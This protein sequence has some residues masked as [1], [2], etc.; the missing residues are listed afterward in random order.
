MGRFV[1]SHPCNCGTYAGENC[2]CETVG[3]MQVNTR[4][5][6]KQHVVPPEFKHGKPAV[7]GKDIPA[8]MFDL[9][10]IGTPHGREIRIEKLVSNYAKKCGYEANTDAKG[11]VWVYVKCDEKS[12]TTMFSCHMDT[13]HHTEQKIQL[14]LSTGVGKEASEMLY[15][16]DPDDTNAGAV[17]G[18][19]DKVGVFILL[20]LMQAGT[21]GLYMFHVGEEDGCVGSKWIRDTPLMAAKI[22]DIKRAIAFDRRGYTDVINQ[23]TGGTCVSP[24]FSLA[25]AAA[26]NAGIAV[27]VTT[28]PQPAFVYAPCPGICTDTNSYIHIIPECTNLSVGYFNQHCEKEFFDYFWLTEWFI[29]AILGIDWEGLPT[30]RDPTPVEAPIYYNRSLYNQGYEHET[31]GVYE[32]PLSWVP[33][34]GMPYDRP[35]SMKLKERIAKYLR[36]SMSDAAAWAIEGFLTSNYR[37]LQSKQLVE[38][39]FEKLKEGVMLLEKA[40]KITYTDT[41]SETKVY[42]LLLEVDEAINNYLT[43][44]DVKVEDHGSNIVAI[45]ADMVKPTT[46]IPKVSEGHKQLPFG[47]FINGHSYKQSLKQVMPSKEGQVWTF[48]YT[49]MDPDALP[50]TITIAKGDATVAMGDQTMSAKVVSKS[51]AKID[52]RHLFKLAPKTELFVSFGTNRAVKLCTADFFSSNAA[53]PKL[54]VVA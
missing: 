35:T 8:L 5:L 42:D 25:L 6:R 7:R 2:Q 21:V 23:Q 44:K 38:Q 20:K 29:P 37:K 54:T 27:E 52:S 26:I 34:D 17:L 30:V 4:P 13:V 48:E 14:M 47:L 41:D 45:I 33:S 43:Y 3:I 51:G 22:K 9:F 12:A 18:A 32:V 28:V 49:S 15:A 1:D 10:H 19:D 16:V 40:G 46:A 39:R 53:K 24:A 36:T 31:D 50:I 11:N